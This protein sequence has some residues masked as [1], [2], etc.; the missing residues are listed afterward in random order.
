MT[1]L[2]FWSVIGVMIVVALQMIG[3]VTEA[4][5]VAGQ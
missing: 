1:R 2:I 3:D 4:L 5:K